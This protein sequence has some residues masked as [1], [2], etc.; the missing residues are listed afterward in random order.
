[1]L[2]NLSYFFPRDDTA[3]LSSTL[4]RDQHINTS[5]YY[6]NATANK[7]KLLSISASSANSNW[8]LADKKQ[9]TPYLAKFEF[10]CKDYFVASSVHDIRHLGRHLKVMKNFI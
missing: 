10:K 5:S 4:G 7:S 3:G 2:I 9:I 1:L 8:M 6:D